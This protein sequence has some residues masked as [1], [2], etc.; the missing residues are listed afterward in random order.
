MAILDFFNRKKSLLKRKVERRRQFFGGSA[1][2]ILRERA[3]VI[4]REIKL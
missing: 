1:V 3:A 2:Q 4:F